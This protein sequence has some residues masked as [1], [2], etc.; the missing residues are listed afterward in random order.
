MLVGR[1]MVGT[2]DA[3]VRANNTTLGARVSGHIAAILP[4]DNSEVK[5]G[6]V[7]FRIDDGDYKIAVDSARAKIATQEATIARIGRQV[8]AQQSAVEQ[9]RRS[10]PPPKPPP[11]ALTSISIASRR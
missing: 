6:D 10:S 11:S 4:R 9:A 7:V 8:A 3:Y 5:A 2:D 1:F